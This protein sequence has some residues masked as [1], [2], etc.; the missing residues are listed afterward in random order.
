MKRVSVLIAYILAFVMLLQFGVSSGA[1]MPV[2]GM[3]ESMGNSELLSYTPTDFTDEQK[4]AADEVFNGALRRQAEKQNVYE[5]IKSA[6]YTVRES[7]IEWIYET[8]G[9]VVNLTDEDYEVFMMFT[10]FDAAYVS[11]ML[12]RL[13]DD[14][15]NFVDA[16]VLL[17]ES[18]L[19][20][21][22]IDELRVLHEVFPDKS[23][24]D[25][26]I[27]MF[28]EFVKTFSLNDDKQE[29]VTVQKET[30][31][32]QQEAAIDEL[33]ALF[34]EGYKTHFIMAAYIVSLSTDISVCDL[35]VT[36]VGEAGAFSEQYDLDELETLTQFL[37]ICPV[38]V[39]VLEEY[40]AEN[41]LTVNEYFNDVR[42]LPQ[43]WISSKISN[44]LCGSIV[45]LRRILNSFIIRLGRKSRSN[46]SP[47]EGVSSKLKYAMSS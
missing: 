28:T 42:A 24:R 39:A 27:K 31:G 45:L 41:N 36:S 2:Q 17:K 25:A 22:T 14:G 11:E 32:N 3:I 30:E 12:T 13:T 4:L 1:T 15:E 34:F 6:T 33:K 7:D 29:E 26:E 35:I 37:S 9:S 10:G 18:R 43:S 40:M 21:F 16:A 47:R 5:Y 8:K 46:F 19:S 44:V 23:E 20:I 38:N